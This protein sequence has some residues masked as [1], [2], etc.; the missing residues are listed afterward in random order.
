MQSSLTVGMSFQDADVIRML[1]M[2]PAFVYDDKRMCSRIWLCFKML[3]LGF[4]STTTAMCIHDEMV[5]WFGTVSSMMCASVCNTIR[6][7]YAF[8]KI[9]GTIFPSIEAFIQ[10]KTQQRR[11]VKPVLDVAEFIIK[12]V[13]LVR[14][15]PLRFS[16]HDEYDNVSMCKIGMTVLNLHA[17]VTIAWWFLFAVVFCT[18]YTHVDMCPREINAN[19]NAMPPNAMP[20]NALPP[21]ALPPNAMVINQE[22]ECCICL[23]KNDS[24][25]TTAPCMH[26]FHAACVIKWMQHNPSCPVCRSSLIPVS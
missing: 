15:I 19:E 14:S 23:D 4:Y 10:W 16:A 22:T 18:M 21:N 5:V 7:E 24:P 1:S 17:L 9:H 12:V 3:G 8:F 13:Y 20:P 26:S 2:Y 11:N 25:W 6:Y